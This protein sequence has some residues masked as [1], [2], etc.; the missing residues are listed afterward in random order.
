MAKCTKADAN[1]LNRYVIYQ[2][3]RNY[4]N[5]TFWQ[6]VALKF[7]PKMGRTEEELKALRRE[8][9]I[10]SELDHP[11]IIKLLEC[12]ETDSEVQKRRSTTSYV[13]GV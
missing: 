11:N 9:S 1:I 8:I 7:I 3:P 2:K 6:I 5:T 10:M 12:C 13:G 4:L